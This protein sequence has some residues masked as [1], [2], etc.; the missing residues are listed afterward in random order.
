MGDGRT[1][2]VQHVVFMERHVAG[3]E[4]GLRQEATNVNVNV[5]FC[6]SAEKLAVNVECFAARNSNVL[7]PGGQIE[8]AAFDAVSA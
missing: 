2:H 7:L 4:E 8:T 6:D 3:W 5:F 1:A